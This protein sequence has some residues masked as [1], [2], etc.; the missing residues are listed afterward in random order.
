MCQDN[1]M[2]WLQID[3]KNNRKKNVEKHW[4]NAITA[5]LKNC[6]FLQI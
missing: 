1:A 2:Q 4:L 6:A 3:G 5:T